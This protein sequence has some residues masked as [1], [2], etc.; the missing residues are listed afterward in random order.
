MHSAGFILAMNP[1]PLSE[2]LLA[3]G[4]Y[5]SI[6]AYSDEDVVFMTK[7]LEVA[8]RGR[9]KVRPNPIVGCVL[10]KDGDV[11]AEGWTTR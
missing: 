7:A 2:S 4:W 11:I 6:M 5:G 9:G 3:D 1:P 8:E 10:V